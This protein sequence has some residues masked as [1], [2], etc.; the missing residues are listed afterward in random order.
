MYMVRPDKMDLFDNIV[1]FHFTNVTTNIYYGLL[2]RLFYL[3]HESCRIFKNSI[4]KAFIE[5]VRE[6]KTNKHL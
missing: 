6:D 4:A 5:I 2:K 3:A 1:I